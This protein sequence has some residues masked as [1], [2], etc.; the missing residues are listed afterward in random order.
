LVSLNDLVTIAFSLSILT[1]YMG[2]LIL[3]LPIP[4]RGLKKWGPT[5]IADGIYVAALIFSYRI[6]ISVVDV[7]LS[8]LGSSWDGFFTW[9]LSRTAIVVGIYEFLAY[10]KS[11]LGSSLIESAV[12]VLINEI[13]KM[14]V[15]LLTTI[16]LVYIYSLIIS[17]FHQ[18]FILLGITLMAI[19]FRIGR[20][21]GATLIATAIV[22]Y[23]GL[24]LMPGFIGLFESTVMGS[25]IPQIPELP[26][27][28]GKVNTLLNDPVSHGVLLVIDQ[29]I[30]EAI[31]VIELDNE[32][33]FHLGPPYDLLPEEF[34]YTIKLSYYGFEFKLNPPYI[35]SENIN[36]TVNATAYGILKCVD[37]Y[38][39][40]LYPVS[41]AVS[42]LRISGVNNTIIAELNIQAFMET[43]LI[44]TY[45]STTTLDSIIVD[46]E[47]YSNFSSDQWVWYGINGTSTSIYISEGPHTVKLIYTVYSKPPLP[48][49]EEQRIIAPETSISDLIMNMLTL[50][51]A[52]IFL[53]ILLPTAF[54]M[55][56]FIIAA[57]LAR[58]IGGRYVK[59]LRL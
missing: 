56:L 19:P 35:S 16:K 8:Y 43:Y 26:S 30:G 6:I 11:I 44:T 51:I 28:D 33:M 21:A 18:L 47:P 1:Y 2:V 20:S 58:V 41:A 29:D 34:N 37:R 24:P 46:G 4:F 59:I 10:V 48:N 27:I 39:A 25:Q 52:L 38:L 13:L 14:L 17:K 12:C 7:L 5:L 3:A 36:E 9:L 54:M 15:P 45:P 50:V 53:L 32:G 40:I 55:M 42:E 49:V 22:F 31:G 57:S 23:I